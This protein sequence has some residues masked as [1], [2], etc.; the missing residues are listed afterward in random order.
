M[1]VLVIVPFSQ[2]VSICHIPWCK[3]IPGDHTIQLNRKMNFKGAV[4]IPGNWQ[5]EIVYELL[6][7]CY[8]PF[9]LFLLK[10]KL[11]V[12]LTLPLN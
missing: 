8:L 1:N 12:I 5:A 6:G 4:F 9:F 10:G 3:H 2:P 7:I 11:W